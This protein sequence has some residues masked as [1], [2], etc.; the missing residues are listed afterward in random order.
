[1]VLLVHTDVCLR[2]DDP[3]HVILGQFW[4]D[5]VDVFCPTRY[6]MGH[7]GEGLPS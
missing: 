1:M 7:F 6:K 5:W 3:I 2:W 4:F